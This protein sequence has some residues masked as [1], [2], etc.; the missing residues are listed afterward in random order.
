MSLNLTIAC[1]AYDRVQDIRSG[2]VQVKGVNLNFLDLPVEETFFRMLQNQEF[3][4]AEMSLSSYV[5][6]MRET[7][8][9]VAIPVFP[10][11]AFR[12]SAIYVREDSTFESPSD[13]R[14]ARIGIPEYQITAAVWLRGIMEEHYDLPVDSV[15]YFT[16]GIDEAGRTEKIPFEAPRGVSITAIPA[17]TTLS[18]MLVSGELDA[19]YSARNPG[20]FNERN[21]T[22]RRLFRDPKTEEK[23]FFQET[24]IFPIMHTM[25]VRRDLYQRHPWVATELL[26]A[27]TKAKDLT[28]SRASETAALNYILPWCW[29]EVEEIRGDFG[30]DW[31]PYGLEGNEVTLKKFLAYSHKQGLAKRL[32]EPADLFAPETLEMVKV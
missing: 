17:Q 1:Q 28:L 18:E 8:P 24:G 9:F 29:D 12:H 7:S 16:G 5:L 25:V 2:D 22:V 15:S 4:I 20:P 19:V 23:K 32:Y 11:R 30:S 21:G 31:W 10:S 27:F 3:D 13:L 14:G 26:K 6:T